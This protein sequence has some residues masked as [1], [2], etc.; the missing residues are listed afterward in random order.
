MSYV[1]GAGIGDAPDWGKIQQ[2]QQAA[3]DSDLTVFVAG[4]TTESCAEWGD[5]AS[6]ELP[7]P[8]GELLARVLAAAKGPVVVVLVHGRPVTLTHNGTDL[9]PQISGVLATWRGGQTAAVA[10]WDVLEGK[11]QPTGRTT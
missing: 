10:G 11:A 1:E 7:E 5:R 6:L 3:A 8:Q 4:D 2:A 9:L